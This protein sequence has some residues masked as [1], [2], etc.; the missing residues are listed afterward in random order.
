MLINSPFK[1]KFQNAQ[2]LFKPWDN[3]KW[4]ENWIGIEN[5]S[6]DD[7]K[8]TLLIAIWCI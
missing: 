2:S 7:P 6:P 5:F 3:S 8:R 1:E 4:F